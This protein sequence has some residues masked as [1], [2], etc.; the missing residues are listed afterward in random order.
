MKAPRYEVGIYGAN[1]WYV[2]DT[3]ADEFVPGSGRKTKG[4]AQ[5]LA[6]WLNEGN[7]RSGAQELRQLLKEILADDGTNLP[8]RN[9]L[10][11]SEW[12]KAARKALAATGGEGDG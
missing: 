11:C 4:Q 10:E 6:R 9:P 2:S 7:D 12:V 3:V 8:P 1:L 5:S